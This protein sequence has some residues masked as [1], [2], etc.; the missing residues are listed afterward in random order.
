MIEQ[1]MIIDGHQDIS[2]NMLTFG[3]DYTL[4][5]VETRQRESTTRVPE[6]NGNTLL[7]WREYQQGRVVLALASLFA[8]PIRFKEGEWDVLVYEDDRR[9]AELYRR[10]VDAYT[11]L[12]EQHPDRFRLVK[13]RADLDDLLAHWNN[14]ALDYA[15]P[16]EE[17][18]NHVESNSAQGERTT[19]GHPVGLVMIMENAEA[20][21][22]PEELEEWWHLGVRQIGPAWGGTRFC[23]GTKEPGPLTGE[24]RALLEAMAD[25]G[26]GLDIA[27]MDESAALE[28]LDIYPGSVVSSHGNALSLLKGSQSNRHLSDRVIAGLVERG[29]L[30]GIV[31]YNAFLKAEWVKGDRRELVGLDRVIAQIDYI[32]Q[33]AGDALHTAIGSDFDGGFG[34]ES[35]P[36]EINTLADLQKIPPLLYEKGYTESDIDAIMGENWLRVLRRILPGEV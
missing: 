16:G 17:M 29:G 22:S 11:R 15:S 19:G 24:G 8:A 27:H 13:K 12:V 4:D 1:P 3:R 35:V 33:I 28:A 34:W 5:A 25:I 9:A 21:R 30:A 26:F 10:Q 20:V 18:D 14:R 32:C 7:G 6:Y 2:W 31:P 23:G 36:R